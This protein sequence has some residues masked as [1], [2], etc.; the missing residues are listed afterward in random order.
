MNQN[1][2]DEPIIPATPTEEDL[3]WVEIG[4]DALR[5]MIG[6]YDEAAKQLITVSGVLQGLYFV[7]I[8]FSTIKDQFSINSFNGVFMILLFISPV[9]LWLL[10]L[11]CSIYVLI[12]QHRGDLSFTVAIDVK[13]RWKLDVGHKSTWLKRAQ[14]L[15]FLGFIP[16]LGSIICYLIYFHNNAANI[17]VLLK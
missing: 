7:A 15:L 5:N 11:G 1:Q 2:N 9:A 12:P 8:S 10:S 6:C 14:R 4:K 13:D 17:S 3:F 16:L